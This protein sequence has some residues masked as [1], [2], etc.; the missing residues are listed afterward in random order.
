M[1]NINR[2]WKVK[3]KMIYSFY[4]ISHILND[5]EI[6][7]VYCAFVQ[8]VLQY[9]K[10]AY[11]RAHTTTIGPLSIAQKSIWRNERNDK[12]TKQRGREMH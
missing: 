11:G 5:R 9:G 6:K 7:I 3:L 1:T 4:Q 2:I 10:V 8:S 12:K